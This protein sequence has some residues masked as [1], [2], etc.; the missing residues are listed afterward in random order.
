[1]LSERLAARGAGNGDRGSEIGD[2]PVGTRRALSALPH[3][4]TAPRQRFSHKAAT[5]WSQSLLAQE[6]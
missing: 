4:E 3:R 6:F 5:A 2:D 1:M